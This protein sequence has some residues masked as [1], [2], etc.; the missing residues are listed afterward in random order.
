MKEQFSIRLEATDKKKIQIIA[1]KNKRTLNSQIEY[2][3]CNAIADYEK[4]SGKIETN[5]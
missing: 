5:E 4:V 2:V 1:K 3:I